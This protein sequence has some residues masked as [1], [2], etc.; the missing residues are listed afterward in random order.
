MTKKISSTYKLKNQWIKKYTES[1]FNTGIETRDNIIIQNHKQGLCAICKSSKMLCG[2]TECPIILRLG[3]ITHIFK[4][5]KGLEID[6]SSPPS[7]FVGRIGYP[8]VHIGPMSPTYYGDTRILDMPE[9]W[10]GKSIDE[11]INYRSQLIRGMHLVN[12]KKPWKAGRVLENT[13]E[14][15]MAEHYVETEMKL[16]KKPQKRLFVDSNVQPIGPTAPV[17]RVDIGYIK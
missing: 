8:Y 7:V 4:N 14:M 11:I 1:R 5:I 3:A 2:R 17:D 9:L 10:F 12:I 6:G 15:S 16:L 13:R